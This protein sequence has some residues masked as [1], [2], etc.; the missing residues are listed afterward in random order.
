MKKFMKG[1]GI[2][3]LILIVLGIIMGIAAGSIQG[4]ALISDTVEKVTDGNVHLNLDI[5]DFGLTIGDKIGE[6]IEDTIG[7]ELFDEGSILY[8]LDENMNFDKAFDIISGD[9]T[10][11]SLGNEVTSLKIEV[12]G[13]EL[14]IVDSG[15]DNF[16]VEAHNTRKFQSYVRNGKLTIKA[17]KSAKNWS[18]LKDCSI[19]LYVPEGFR[20]DHVEVELGAGM[21]DL[22]NLYANELELE[23]GAGQITGE[24]LEISKASVSVGMG[25]VHIDD[26]Q[27]DKLD[28]EVGMGSLYLTAD[29]RESAQMECSVGELELT[30]KGQETDFNY[31]VEAAI[32]NVEIGNDSY[33]GLA[34]ERRINNSA[35]KTISV[36][37]A[38]GNVTV[39][40]Q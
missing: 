30:V 22:G 34:Q 20:F 3:A 5:G 16:Y 11:Y 21:L 10:K 25:E 19:T 13:C 7:D 40:F 31:N 9:V 38:M 27:V 32:G 8:E 24:Y 39:D 29:I 6:A 1:C 14:N 37:C 36:E 33:S 18:A 17:T 12:G 35:D 28:A 2:A 15:D 23:V 4:T 26:M